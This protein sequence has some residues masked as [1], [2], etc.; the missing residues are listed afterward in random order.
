MSDKR[1]SEYSESVHLDTS[2]KKLLI[3]VKAGET[4]EHEHTG[5]VTLPEYAHVGITF[6]ELIA[7]CRIAAAGL[8]LKL[9]EELTD[10]QFKGDTA[11]RLLE[12]VPE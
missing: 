8:R 9:R 10:T 12:D 5:W 7:R 1:E 4:G 6:D 11:T 3:T 2:S